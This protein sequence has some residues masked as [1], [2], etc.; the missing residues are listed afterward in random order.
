MITNRT[1]ELGYTELEQHASNEV[2]LACKAFCWRTE[3]L[4]VY[5]SCIIWLPSGVNKNNLNAYILPHGNSFEIK[6]KNPRLLADTSLL[7]TVLDRVT[8]G[9][10]NR[11]MDG[12]LMI[13]QARE[14]ELY[15]ETAEHP[16][17]NQEVTTRYSQWQYRTCTCTLSP[18]Y[19]H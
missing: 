5:F 10:G 12:N 1:E 15:M 17:K 6:Y 8:G 13:N 19:C 7:E 11:S 16:H 14:T 4:N 3:T 18:R 2:K 9:N